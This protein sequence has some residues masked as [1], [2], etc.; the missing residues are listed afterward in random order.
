MTCRCDRDVISTKYRN[1]IAGMNFPF[2]LAYTG[3]GCPHITGTG[4]SGTEYVTA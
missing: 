1:V 2:R 3:A 4:K